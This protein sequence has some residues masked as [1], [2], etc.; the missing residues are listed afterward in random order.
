MEW[1]GSRQVREWTLVKEGI[2]AKKRRLV[3]VLFLGVYVTI[4]RAR[5]QRSLKLTFQR[6]LEKNAEAEV[7]PQRLHT[8]T[9]AKTTTKKQQ[10]P[11]AGIG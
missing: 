7:R 6:L 2:A 4:Y 8:Y 10:Q 5:T 1:L 3:F 11:V 9:H